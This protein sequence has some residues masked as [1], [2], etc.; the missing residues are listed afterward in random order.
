VRRPETY[1]EAGSRKFG[2]SAD[3]PHDFF[4]TRIFRL[5]GR[6]PQLKCDEAA[7]ARDEM[8]DQRDEI[9]PITT[10]F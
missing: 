2:I 5:R 10:I 7:R 1:D 9:L 8:D 3:L 6:K 4:M